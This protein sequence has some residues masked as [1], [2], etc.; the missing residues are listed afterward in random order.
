MR[1]IRKF[2]PYGNDPL[3]GISLTLYC[4]TWAIFLC[5][6][7]LKES[8]SK[9]QSNL[10]AVYSDPQMNS[11]P[12]HLHAVLVHQGQASL[13]HYWAYVRKSHAC[14]L[15]PPTSTEI[16]TSTSTEQPLPEEDRQDRGTERPL[17]NHRAIQYWAGWEWEWRSRGGARGGPRFV[18]GEL[19]PL[20]VTGERGE[21]STPLSPSSLAQC[22]QMGWRWREG[23]QWRAS[24]QM[25]NL[26][27]KF[28]DVS[29]TE[30]GWGGCAEGVVW[31]VSEHECLL[32]YLCQ[33][34]AAW[35]VH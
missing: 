30:V 18:N 28:N 11:T 6:S 33:Q 1:K 25:R 7:E 20:R 4:K 24:N 19:S 16:S 13:G 12:Y 15:P 29:V 17:A 8:I 14:L 35:A 26:W 21:E 10:D 32:S 2:P 3:Y 27:L 23:P 31:W 5:F 34:G 9:T 22:H